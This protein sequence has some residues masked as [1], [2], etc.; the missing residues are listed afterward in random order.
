MLLG[1]ALDYVKKAQE[2]TQNY[3]QIIQALE[4]AIEGRTYS[5]LETKVDQL[6]QQ[7]NSCQPTQP[8]PQPQP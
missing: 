8:Q 2:I 1:Q 7:F 3:A 4:K 5:N 6:I